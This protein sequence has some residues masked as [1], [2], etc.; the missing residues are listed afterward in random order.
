MESMCIIK[1]NTLVNSTVV[2]GLPSPGLWPEHEKSSFLGDSTKYRPGRMSGTWQST[3][4]WGRL[5]MITRMLRGT[6]E[7]GKHFCRIL[8]TEKKER[9]SGSC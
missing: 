2:P 9:E 7:F 3:D 5:L 6:D 4:T 8:L 1:K